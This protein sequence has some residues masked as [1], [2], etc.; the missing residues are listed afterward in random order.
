LPSERPTPLHAWWPAAVWIA[1][2][3]F[4][5]TDYL[6]SDNTS[7][8]LY[9][10]LTR[11]FGEINLY[12]FLVFHHYLRKAGHV[13]GYGILCLLLLRGFRATLARSRSW[14]W[15]PATLAWAGT[16]FVACLDEWHQSFIPSRHGSAWDVVL[17]S[18]AGLLFLLIA[19]LWRRSPPVEQSAYD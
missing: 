2:I 18:V 6:S 3:A 7:D 11:I 9:S 5:S 13:L 4:E 15:R 8:V 19:H 16:A 1:L 10:L 17:D 12:D 14:S